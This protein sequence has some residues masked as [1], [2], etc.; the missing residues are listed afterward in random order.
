M[1]EACGVASREG[2]EEKCHSLLIATLEQIGMSILEI[3]ALT[4]SIA[5]TFIL[6]EG[7]QARD[8]LHV[9]TAV[10]SQVS[11]IATSVDILPIVSKLL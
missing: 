11:K 5:F 2:G 9:G 1:L 6:Q 8:A 7:L 3:K 10:M 4:Y